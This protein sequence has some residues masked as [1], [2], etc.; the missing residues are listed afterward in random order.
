MELDRGVSKNIQL[1]H[2][3]WKNVL[4]FFASPQLNG[5]EDKVILYQLIFI[6]KERHMF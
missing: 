4:K 5:L 2:P 3:S 6:L 1:A